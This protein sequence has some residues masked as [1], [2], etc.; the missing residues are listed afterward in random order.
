MMKNDGCAGAFILAISEAFIWSLVS[1]STCL[2]A[3]GRVTDLS[4][5][6]SP[7]VLSVSFREG[8]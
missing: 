5:S 7:Q 6:S 1:I 3:L 2:L 8:H 4:F